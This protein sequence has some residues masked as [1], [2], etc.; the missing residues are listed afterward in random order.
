MK[1]LALLLCM[2][3]SSGTPVN[4]STY[5]HVMELNHFFNERGEY[6]FSQ[7]I[8]WNQNPATMRLEVGYWSLIDHQPRFEN[9]LHKWTAKDGRTAHSCIFRESWTQVD[10][11]REDQKRTPRESRI[12]LP[13]LP[14]P[15]KET[16]G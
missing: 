4:R 8:L 5:F 13:D 12:G 10:P 7:I 11:E 14:K 1:V 15:K 2:L 9:G 3:L 6:V 16:N